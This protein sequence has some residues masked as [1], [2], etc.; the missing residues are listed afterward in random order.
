MAAKSKKFVLEPFRGSDCLFL[1]KKFEKG[2]EKKNVVILQFGE[3]EKEPEKE[4]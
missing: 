1:L 3:E 4:A 2:D